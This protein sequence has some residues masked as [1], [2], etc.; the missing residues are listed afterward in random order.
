MSSNVLFYMGIFFYSEASTSELLENLGANA[1]S[2]LEVVSRSCKNDLTYVFIIITHPERD[3]FS[4][5]IWEDTPL[6]PLD[7]VRIH[8]IS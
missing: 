3:K 6:Y 4:K 7:I 2:S 5:K 1:S 8:I